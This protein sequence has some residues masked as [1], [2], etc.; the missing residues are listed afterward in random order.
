MLPPPMGPP[1]THYNSTTNTIP[2][3][4]QN[5]NPRP[6]GNCTGSKVRC[7]VSHPYTKSLCKRC[8][9][10]GLAECPPYV[11]RNAGKRRA[12]N[13]KRNHAPPAERTDAAG[14]VFVYE[15]VSTPNNTEVS[16]VGRSEIDSVAQHNQS[17]GNVHYSVAHG[18]GDAI[19]GGQ[20]ANDIGSVSGNTP[21][22]STTPANKFE[23]LNE[24]AIIN[25]ETAVENPIFAYNWFDSFN[26]VAN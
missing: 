22:T 5:R 19:P 6:C 17:A 14:T 13:R 10:Y 4:N 21:S 20:L 11:Q 25:N 8:E 16:Q 7:V 15:N 2:S 1:N 24:N 23:A 26:E 3:R 9:E 12:P 18:S